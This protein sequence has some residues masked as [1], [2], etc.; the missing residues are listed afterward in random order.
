LRAEGQ[1][2]GLWLAPFCVRSDARLY[3]EHPDWVV[4]DPETGAPA[5]VWHHW[6]GPVYGLDLTHP[7]VLEHLR[8]LTAT[9]T[10]EWGFSVLKLDFLHFGAQPGTRHDPSCTGLEAV[11]RGLAAIREAAGIDVHLLGCGAPMAA[12]LGLVDSMRVGQDVGLSWR[13][14]TPE[15]MSSVSTMYAC[16]NTVLR[17]WQHRTWWVNDPDCVLIREN[18]DAPPG[19]AGPAV[20]DPERRFLLTV[21]ALTGGSTISGDSLR[22]LSAARWRQLGQLLPPTGLA[23]RW[24]GGFKPALPDVLHLRI[25]TAWDAWHLVALLN[26]DDAAH[27]VALPWR[28]LGLGGPHELFD[29]WEGQPRPAV[30]GAFDQVLP[31]HGAALLALRPVREHP[32]LLGDD[33]H[34]AQGQA[35]VADCRFEPAGQTLVL[36]LLPT[37]NRAG[38]LWLSVPAAYRVAEVQ[39]LEPG[40]TWAEA[41]A[42]ACRLDLE[43]RA[44][45]VVHVRFMGA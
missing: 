30:A 9:L 3:A 34:F 2:P 18:G 5:P 45:R 1:A 27:T 20:T 33:R 43:V 36:E 10:V 41:G 37:P 40:E 4:R 39:G 35:G 21:V 44:P 8:R 23:A 14:D 6:G 19:V 7:A 15:N 28:A 32:W 11:R 22:S 24:V 13:G 26:W 16:M 12:S 38:R 25:Q 29:V 42:G 31:P 17:L